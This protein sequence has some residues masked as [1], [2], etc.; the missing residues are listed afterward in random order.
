[1]VVVLVLGGVD[2]DGGVVMVV[3]VVVVDKYRVAPVPPTAGAGVAIPTTVRV[4]G[5]VEP[6]LCVGLPATRA[7][8]EGRRT[9]LPPEICDAAVD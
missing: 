7:L 3:V 2:V 6:P 4:A 8:A 5:G 9:Q 1:M